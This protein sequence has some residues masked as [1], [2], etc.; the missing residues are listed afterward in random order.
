MAQDA[1]WV[2][3]IGYPYGMGGTVTQD[4]SRTTGVSLH[5]LAGQ[6]TLFTAAG[7][8]TAATFTV[9]NNKVGADDVVIP[10]VKSGTNK[11]AAVVTAVADGSFDVTF[12]AISGTASDAPVFGYVV[13]KTDPS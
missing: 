9:T 12:W 8:A 11:Y 7:S 4:T 10:C 3:A 6:I 1:M 5:K 13:F 2:D